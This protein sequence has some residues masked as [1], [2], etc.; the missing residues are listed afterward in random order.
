MKRSMYLMI[1]IIALL[2]LI[3]GNVYSADYGYYKLSALGT[4]QKIAYVNDVPIELDVSPYI[5]NGRT[6]VPI[7]FMEKALGANIKWDAITNTATVIVQDKTIVITINK[8]IAF[9]NEQP[10]SMD[11]PAEIKQ[12]RT[13]V[14]IR[15]ISENFG[16]TV[17]YDANYKYNIIISY[18]DTT[19]WK[20]FIEPKNGLIV[21]YPPDWAEIS[22]NEDFLKL[23]S[24]ADSIFEFKTDPRTLDAVIAEKR[25]FYTNNGWELYLDSEATP[26]VPEN[27]VILKASNDPE[28]YNG[29]VFSEGE[30]TYI[31]EY[32][33]K[34]IVDA[35]I[36]NEIIR[37][38]SEK[39]SK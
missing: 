35:A 17:F 26:G 34:D 32:I 10:I 37:I 36:Y 22:I 31:I 33:G 13:F 5:K 24:P 15:F 14:P 1:L 23:E 4:G 8:K 18:T 9:V 7:R 29:Y 20:E 2:L 30:T 6:L 11:V 28:H 27:G 19:N 25:A 3:C 16:A 21:L 38:M 12:G 39:A